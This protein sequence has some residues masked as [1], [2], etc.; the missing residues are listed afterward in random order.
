MGIIYIDISK[1]QSLIK[2]IEIKLKKTTFVHYE[3]LLSCN[4]FS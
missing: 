1:H 3:H 4:D 2:N